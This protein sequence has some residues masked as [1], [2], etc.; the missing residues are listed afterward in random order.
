M[1]PGDP[2]FLKETPWQLVQ[3]LGKGK[4]G[5]SWLVSRNGQVAVYK[6]IHHEPVSYYQFGDKFAAE[7]RAY[8]HLKEA[9]V[10]LPALLEYDE[11]AEWLL[12]SYLEGPTI[13]EQVAAGTLKN[14]VWPLIFRL[15]RHLQV[16]GIN[17]DW[18][19]ANFIHTGGKLFYVDYEWNGYD[20]EW[21][22]VNWGIYYWVNQQGMKKF[23]ETGDHTAINLNGTGKPITNQL[24]NVVARLISLQSAS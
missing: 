14:D 4:S 15:S 22:F 17:L 5:Y 12:K 24:E 7:I 20:P 18:F 11:K 6:Q 13:A 16:L 21:D 3:L 23:L 9:Q 1:K 2:L 8:H 10:N 19:P